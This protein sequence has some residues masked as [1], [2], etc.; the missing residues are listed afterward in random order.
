MGSDPIVT[1]PSLTVDESLRRSCFTPGGYL[2]KDFDLM[3]DELYDKNSS[4]R[5][6]VLNALTARP[7]TVSEVAAALGR[8]RNGHLVG[9]MKDLVQAGFL[10]EERGVNPRTGGLRQEIRYRICDNYVRFYLHTVLPRKAMIEDGTYRFESLERLPGWET[11]LGFQFENLVLGAMPALVARLHL[12]KSRILSIAPYRR[13]AD[14]NGRGCQIDCLIQTRRSLY[15]V[16]IKRQTNIGV[17]IIDE[18]EQKVKRLGYSGGTSVRPILVYDGSLSPMVEEDGYFAATIPAV[19]LFGLGGRIR[20]R[21]AL[22]RIASKQG[23]ALVYSLA[24]I[25]RSM[26]EW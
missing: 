21:G 14:D 6:A 20:L 19:E 13:N 15:V 9:T 8:S 3:F 11:I 24:A 5:K 1:D 17:E 26:T 7:M 10:A 12:D 23:R 2:F 4:D 18:V 25:P 22:E 16:E